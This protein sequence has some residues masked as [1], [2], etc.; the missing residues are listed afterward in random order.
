MVLKTEKNHQKSETL[1]YF[2][3]QNEIKPVIKVCDSKK[4]VVLN[5][6]FSTEEHITL[7][8]KETGE[9]LKNHWYKNKPIK[10][11]DNENVEIAKSLYYKDP[12]R[13]QFYIN[14]SLIM[15]HTRSLSNHL[16]SRR[17]NINNAPKDKNKYR[18]LPKATI[19]IPSKEIMVSFYL[20]PIKS[21]EDNTLG[22][23]NTTL[24]ILI[25]KIEN[26]SNEARTISSF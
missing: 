22:Q 15:D 7:H 21:N 26:I 18:K 3:F 24:G 1:I 8:P 13:H 23:I 11:W 5:F 25:L 10:N 16:V 6:L 9:I 14:H 19:E 2:K 20:Q 12:Q 17:I 4:Q